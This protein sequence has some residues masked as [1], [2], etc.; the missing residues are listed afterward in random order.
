MRWE[1]EH[2]NWFLK[3]NRFGRVPEIRT[4]TYRSVRGVGGR[5]PVN[6]KA[7]LCSPAKPPNADIRASSSSALVAWPGQASLVEPRRA[8]SSDGR[9]G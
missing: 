8:M 1:T 7:G 4:K 5:I 2:T 6:C 9:G 3:Y